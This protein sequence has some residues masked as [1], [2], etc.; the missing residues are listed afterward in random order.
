MHILVLANVPP[1]AVGGAEMQVLRLA[2]E[3]AACGHQVTIAGPANTEAIVGNLTILGLPVWRWSRVSRGLTY[4]VSAVKLLWFRRRK[5]DVIYCRF[6]QEQAIAACLAKAFFRLRQPIIACPAGA[7]DT[8][9]AATLRRSPF[10]KFW[11]AL[12]NRY[13]ACINALTPELEREISD[14]GVRQPAVVRIPNCVEVGSRPPARS[15]SV[16]PI[17]MVTVGRLVPGKGVDVLISACARLAQRGYDFHLE[18]VGDGPERATLERATRDAGL[19]PS[20]VFAGTVAPS[21]I[22]GKLSASDLFVL[23]SRFEGMSGSLLEAFAGG[24]PAVVSAIGGTA[25]VDEQIGWR[26]PAGDVEALADAMAEAIDA[27]RNRLR[28][29]GLRA[30][31]KARREVSIGHVAAAYEEEFRRLI[32]G[33]VTSR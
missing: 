30:W 33:S 7:G 24:L 28:E 3:W 22:A 31:E 12:F 9:D 2:R 16:G 29:M 26:V 32:G 6:L 27:G 17:R 11:V 4:V 25:I 19:K 8:G 23:P 15:G 14:L 13:L 20:I 10:R 1:H 21:D 5:I 18:I